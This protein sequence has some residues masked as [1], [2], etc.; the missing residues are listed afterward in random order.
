M[1][2]M[3]TIK[4]MVMVIA[5]LQMTMIIHIRL[6]AHQMQIVITLKILRETLIIAD[7]SIV[8]TMLII[9]FVSNLQYN[10]VLIIPLL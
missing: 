3:T 1:D 2:Q 8:V 5:K 9:K 7:L 10:V 6:L 4:T